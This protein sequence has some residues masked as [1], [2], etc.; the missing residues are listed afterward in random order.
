MHF[1]SDRRYAVGVVLKILFYRTK[2]PKEAFKKAYG[3]FLIFP[4][5]DQKHFPETIMLVNSISNLFN[6]IIYRLNI[7]FCIIT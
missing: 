6:N 1:I 5:E 7:R 3:P 2:E 4:V